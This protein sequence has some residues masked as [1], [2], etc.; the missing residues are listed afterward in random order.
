MTSCRPIFSANALYSAAI[1]SNV[2]R[3]HFDRVHLV[4]GEH[5]VP[6]AEQRHDVAVAVRLR[7][8]PFARI[9][10][11]HGEIGGRSAGRHVAGVLLM[12]RR[13][14]DDELAL[15]GREEAVGDVDGDALLA[16]GLQAVDQQRHVERFAGGAEARRILGES[17]ELVFVE[18]LA[19]V[20]QAAD[21]GRLAVIDRAAGEEA[22]QAAL[23]GGGFGLPTQRA[24][25]CH[26]LVHQK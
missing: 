22:Q 4:D 3:S 12:A 23:R 26:G 7:Q 15:A 6:D 2:A 25:F 11:Q 17:R 16:L 20:E 5:D 21:Q 13:V 8:Q 19:V 24:G 18:Q 1:F 10:Q 9:D 14:G